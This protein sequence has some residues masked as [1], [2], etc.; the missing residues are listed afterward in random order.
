MQEIWTYSVSA[1]EDKVYYAVWGGDVLEYDVKSERWKDYNDPDGETEIVLFKDQGLIHEITVSVSYANR[2][3]WV[4]TYFGASR[5][6][7]REW[8]NFLSKD[9]GL[10]S[11]FLNQVK[12]IDGARTWF[13]TDQGLAYF[14]GERWA[15]YRRSLDTQEPEMLVR[16]AQGKTST[17]PVET[18]P[19]HHYTFGV[20]FQGDDLWVATAKGLSH[21]IRIKSGPSQ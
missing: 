6:D 7:G 21:G 1:A 20:D 8:R 10:P 15:T 16:D 3:L 11:N 9:S 5:Y 18:A 4:G 17:L 19:A 2:I 12:T 13:S 14:D